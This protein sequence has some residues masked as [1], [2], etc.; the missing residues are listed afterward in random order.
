MSRYSNDMKFRYEL[1][2]YEMTKILSVRTEQIERGSEAFVDE[3]TVYD[4]CESL[5]ILELLSGNNPLSVKRTVNNYSEVVEVK[6][7][8][9]N[10]F[11]KKHLLKCIDDIR[12][13]NKTFME[14][15]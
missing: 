12:E 3:K 6:L 2:K 9:I 11:K 13:K 15:S 1:T 8:N 5:A 4:D 14:Q 7:L 10:S